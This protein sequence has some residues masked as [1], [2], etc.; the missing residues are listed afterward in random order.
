MSYAPPSKV[1]DR[2]SKIPAAKAYLDR[3][4]YGK[5]LGRSDEYTY[6]FGAALTQYGINV[7]DQVLKGKTAPPDVNTNGVFDW[8]IQRQMGLDRPQAP[9][10]W[11]PRFATFVWRGTGGVP[12]E[13]PVSRICQRL[14]SLVAE[15]NLPWDAT[16]GGI[17]VGA[18]QG[19][20][21]AP[22]M[23]T[24]IQ[25]G[26]SFFQ[27]EYVKTMNSNPDFKCNLIGYSAGAILCQLAREWV[28]E[29]YPQSY[30]ASVTL[31]DPTR[32]ENA[33]FFGRTVWGNGIADFALGDPKDYRHAWLT[34]EKDIYAQIPGG[35]VGQIMELVYAEVARFAFTDILA[36]AQRMVAA[37]PKALEL[38]G[39]SA[40]DVVKALSGGIGGI[41]G[42]GLTQFVMAMGGLIPTGKPDSELKGTAAAARASVLGLEFL[43]AGTGPH[44]RYEWD[45]AWP[46]G[47]TFVDFGAMH[48]R[49]YIGRL[50]P[51]GFA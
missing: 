5:N 33:A 42:F 38:L 29:H 28:L 13:D 11:E 35:V 1:G 51:A 50:K 25:D 4:S 18:T 43:F 40:P 24:A 39:I 27:G 15:I 19:G 6:P 31:G 7:H 30:I 37:I 3:F 14:G 32:P 9:R 2:H 41:F 10:V 23:W 47:P 22:A 12:G 17:P 16:M 34:H 36:F 21:G 44:I 49:D 46:G 48:L 26:L 45:E 8:A 20:I